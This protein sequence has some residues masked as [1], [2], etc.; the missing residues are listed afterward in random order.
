MSNSHSFDLNA[1]NPFDDLRGDNVVIHESTYIDAPCRIGK[2]TTIMHFSH[3]MPHSII[4]ENTHVGHNVTIGTGVLI[5]N[6]VTV[7]N[8]SLLNSGVILE[9]EVYCGAST[10]F[11]PL[12]RMKGHQKTISRISPT[13]V[14]K[15]AN[16]GAN[17][18]IASG[19]T[20]G[21]HAFLEAGTVVDGIVPDFA[22]MLGN[23]MKLV[24]WRCQCGEALTFKADDTD[25]KACGKTYKRENR[26]R[27][28]Q[29]IPHQPENLLEQSG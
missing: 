26:Q 19:V 20:I 16:I 2:N 25:C 14:K 7:M 8:N 5:G 24:S 10:V 27:I 12:G 29:K 21:Q 3:V 4:G 15:G 6:H 18:S 17:T 11:N 13:L 9:D 22:L 28:I 23:P 1:E